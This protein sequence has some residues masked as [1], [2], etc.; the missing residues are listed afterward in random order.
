MNTTETNNPLLNSLMEAV[1]FHINTLI[2]DRLKSINEAA[3]TDYVQRAVN[4]RFNTAIS[5]YAALV[6]TAVNSRYAELVQE[7]DKRIN[8][9]FDARMQETGAVHSTLAT[10]DTALEAK[11]D[12]KIDAKIADAMSDHTSEEPHHS[13]DYIRDVVSEEQD[14]LGVLEDKVLDILR[15]NNY[16]DTSDVEGMFDCSNDDFARGVK[17]VLSDLSATIK[18]D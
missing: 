7:T 11:I 8:E 18:F 5:D 6:Q 3:I 14:R 9:I 15:D 1:N 10:L 12:A 4:A 17:E 13:S 16:V 2:E